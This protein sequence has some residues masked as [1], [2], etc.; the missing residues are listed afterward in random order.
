MLFQFCAFDSSERDEPQSLFRGPFTAGGSGQIFQI[1]LVVP[2][3]HRNLRIIGKFGL[4]RRPLPFLHDDL[5]RLDPH[6]FS[7]SPLQ[8]EDDHDLH[9]LCAG[10]DGAGA[11]EPA[12]Y[13]IW[14]TRFSPPASPGTHPRSAPSPPGPGPCPAC[15]P[16]RRRP[17]Q[18]RSSW[19]PSR[20]RGPP[21]PP[22][23]SG[24]RGG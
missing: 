4:R 5:Y 1:T 22:P 9:P 10:P 16:P 2:N 21:R 3:A 24:P 14:V 12:G 8:P 20:R 13:L 11:E 19:R 15:S 6:A 7:A 18:N 23:A 17:R